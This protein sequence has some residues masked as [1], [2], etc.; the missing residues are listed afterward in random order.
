ML[1]GQGRRGA[2]LQCEERVGICRSFHAGGNVGHG[3]LLLGKQRS[4][5]LSISMISNM[6]YSAVSGAF[7]AENYLGYLSENFCSS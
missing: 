6:S 1:V 7:V 5:D 4:L 3:E 2:V